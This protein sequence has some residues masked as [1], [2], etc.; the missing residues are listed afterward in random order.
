M[1]SSIPPFSLIIKTFY[2]QSIQKNI[3][4][5]NTEPFLFDSSVHSTGS[6]LRC[7]IAHLMYYF[8]SCIIYYLHVATQCTK[9]L[10]MLM[11]TRIT[12]QVSCAFDLNTGTSDVLEACH[13][14]HICE[15]FLRGNIYGRRYRSGCRSWGL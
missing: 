8:E 10:M 3:L 12:H 14:S 2:F 4:I 15:L 7:E 1:L 6:Y 9:N 13:L 11:L 5:V